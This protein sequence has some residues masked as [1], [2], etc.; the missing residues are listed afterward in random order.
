M[1]H[2]QLDHGGGTVYP[3]INAIGANIVV[4]TLMLVGMRLALPTF[5][6]L[7]GVIPK[8][9]LVAMSEQAALNIMR[10]KETEILSMMGMEP[11][12]NNA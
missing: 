8:N 4:R 2:V 7:S 9:S 6:S 12:S 1:T 5:Q 3:R 11:I 10:R